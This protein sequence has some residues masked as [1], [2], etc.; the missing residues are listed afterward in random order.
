MQ[1]QVRIIMP[2]NV[3][4]YS[5]TGDY[6]AVARTAALTA[7]ACGATSHSIRAIIAL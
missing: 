3:V 5:A 7:Q 1:Y 6:T 4:T 2:G